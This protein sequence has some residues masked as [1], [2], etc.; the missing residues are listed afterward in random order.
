MTTHL[1]ETLQ[2]DI[3]HIQGL[4][5]RMGDFTVRMLQDTVS[6]LENG[7][8]EWA[9]LIVLRD[10]R[11]DSME[12][13]ID[14]LCL[15]FLVRHQPAAGHLRFTYTAL[16]INFEL[17][18]IGD[19]AESIARQIIKLTDLN[20]HAPKALFTQITSASISMLHN[21]VMAFVRQDEALAGVTEQIEEQ[22]D[23]LRNQ[24]NSELIHL[25][26]TGQISLAALA[27]LM[28]IARRFERVSDQA[29]SICQETIYLCTGE[30]AKHAASQLY[31]V[32]FVDDHHGCLSRLAEAIGR[33]LGRSDLE[34]YSAGVD[35]R[36]L[37][38]PLLPMLKAKGVSDVALQQ[39][40]DLSSFEDFQLV[41][42]LSPAAGQQL[43]Q[44]S[45]KSAQLTWAM[46]DPCRDASGPEVEAGLEV[47]ARTL[48]QKISELVR[49]LLGENGSK[50]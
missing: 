29:K 18:R 6:A 32:L 30:Y 13:E 8:R 50:T 10:Q 12:K 19:Y 2:R 3:Q 41:V 34:F 24:V 46:A 11:V 20:C 4:I 44:P 40:R 23:L 49:R 47:V 25:L 16:Q 39:Q 21:A 48:T 31:R 37:P 9:S 27:P 7:D 26:Q 43:P 22:V 45:R 28:T 14:Q 36:P 17:E 33:R 5:A 15:A 42:A 35:P 1:E 38:A